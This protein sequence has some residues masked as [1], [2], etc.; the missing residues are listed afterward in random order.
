MRCAGGGEE[1]DFRFLFACWSVSLFLPSLWSVVVCVLCVFD[2]D[3]D[4]DVD[5]VGVVVV[6]VAVMFVSVEGEMLRSV[7]R[8]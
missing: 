1:R 4:D 8:F 3:V 6:V 5:V 7:L 2:V